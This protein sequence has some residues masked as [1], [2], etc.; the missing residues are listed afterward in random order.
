MR[1]G[2]SP[3]HQT[4]VRHWGNSTERV[5]A[6]LA[7][8]SCAPALSCS[9]PNGL[10]QTATSAR[11]MLRVRQVERDLGAK[12]AVTCLGIPTVVLIVSFAIQGPAASWSHGLAHSHPR[13]GDD[14]PVSPSTR[15]SSRPNGNALSSSRRSPFHD[16]GRSRSPPDPARAVGHDPPSIP[17]CGQPEVDSREPPSSELCDQ[18]EARGTRVCLGSARKID[19]V[20]LT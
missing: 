8:G 18:M 5:W 7:A 4:L 17:V 14:T 11:A 3:V 13:S 6:E 16:A 15:S 12:P 20:V 2:Y 10:P 1:L 19:R 9:V